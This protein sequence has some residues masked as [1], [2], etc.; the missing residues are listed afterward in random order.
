M[1]LHVDATPVDQQWEHDILLGGIRSLDSKDMPIIRLRYRTEE[2]DA[3][4]LV[5]VEANELSQKNKPYA[6]IE[7]W[8]IDD[9]EIRQDAVIPFRQRQPDTGQFR[10]TSYIPL[11]T[12]INPDGQWHELLIDANTVLERTIIEGYRLQFEFRRFTH[13]RLIGKMDIDDI[14]VESNG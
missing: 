7:A 4:I 14:S 6:V 12:S 8:G 3:K 9:D 13:I 5:V 1:F 10:N 11:A 2:P